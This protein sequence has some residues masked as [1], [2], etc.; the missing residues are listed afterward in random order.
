MF[1]SNQSNLWYHDGPNTG[2]ILPSYHHS[3]I[4][5]SS[6][7]PKLAACSLLV[8]DCPVSLISPS[9]RP[10]T[11]VSISPS[12]M[13]S[14]PVESRPN[15]SSEKAR[16]PCGARGPKV[17]S[18]PPNSVAT[19]TRDHNPVC[20]TSALLE[21]REQHRLHT[22]ESQLEDRS[23]AS[24]ALCCF[25]NELKNAGLNTRCPVRGTGLGK[26]WRV[27][28]AWMWNA[29]GLA[30][31]HCLGCQH[32]TWMNVRRKKMLAFSEL[33]ASVQLRLSISELHC[34]MLEQY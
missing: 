30:S 9:S 21:D 13:R 18:I 10:T 1:I 29:W 2:G 6:K 31:Y 20:E 34:S 17:R 22:F 28:K 5:S 26:E 14:A 7:Y 32:P 4:S 19:A 24:R 12:L 16:C 33:L 8:W 11:P 27:P 15:T 25:R 23:K 3:S